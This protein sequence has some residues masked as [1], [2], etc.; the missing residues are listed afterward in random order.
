MHCMNIRRVVSLAT[1]TVVWAS[2]ATGCPKD[3]ATTNPDAGPQRTRLVRGL[4]SVLEQP[5]ERLPDGGLVALYAVGGTLELWA[6]ERAGMQEV[7]AA[8]K[9]NSGEG[10]A[11][12][13]EKR[14]AAT[15]E[16][17]A[18]ARAVKGREPVGE[19]AEAA[20][21][22]VLSLPFGGVHSPVRLD[23][24]GLAQTAPEDCKDTLLRPGAVGQVLA[25][26]GRTRVVLLLDGDELKKFSGCVARTRPGPDAPD[27]V[28][29]EH[30]R[31]VALME[32]GAK[33]EVAVLLALGAD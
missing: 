16:M 19:Q 6:V 3:D 13:L 32:A 21:K 12:M 4:K 26:I 20:L 30:A 29:A 27:T 11:K 1:A 33:Q 23:Q 5:V 25:G 18:R 10:L 14:A 15:P 17:V 24:A 8:V 2:F 7:L 22:G 31:L 28:K 9:T